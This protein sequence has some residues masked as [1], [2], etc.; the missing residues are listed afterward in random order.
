[1]S[2]PTPDDVRVLT[3]SA[4]RAEARKHWWLGVYVGIAVVMA[5]LPFAVTICLNDWLSSDRAVFFG[6]GSI[7]YVL[8]AVPLFWLALHARRCS[9]LQLYLE[10]EYRCRADIARCFQSKTGLCGENGKLA[11]QIDKFTHLWSE[12]PAW[13]LALPLT[14]HRCPVCGRE[15]RRCACETCKDQQS[16][17]EAAR[18]KASGSG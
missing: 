17:A 16:A 18:S 9:V 3:E 11:G 5:L 12:S 14:R 1:M 6:L 4:D 13:I 10:E 8:T 15:C 2:S 7:L